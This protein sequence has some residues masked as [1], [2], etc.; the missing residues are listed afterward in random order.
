MLQ[1]KYV[2]NNKVPPG[3]GGDVCTYLPFF[4]RKT[5][6]KNI[7]M[8]VIKMMLKFKENVLKYCHYSTI[9]LTKQRC[10]ELRSDLSRLLRFFKTKV[11]SVSV[12]FASSTH[13]FYGQY[14]L[15]K[16]FSCKSLNA[17]YI[18]YI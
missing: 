13:C 14:V 12:D 17:K 5:R 9:K 16:H 4:I 3:G 10:H 2:K 11:P 1:L 15:L 8:K 7:K 18:Y 6:I